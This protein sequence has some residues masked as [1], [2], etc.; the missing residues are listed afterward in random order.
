MNFKPI[1]KATVSEEP[2]IN[3]VKFV[4]ITA[5]FP[6]HKSETAKS[7]CCG[8]IINTSMQALFYEN[9]MAGPNEFLK[10]E[11]APADASSLNKFI[12]S[13]DFDEWEITDSNDEHVCFVHDLIKNSTTKGAKKKNKR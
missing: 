10:F 13:F 11:E 7:L 4:K 1:T 6:V 9:E 3:D 5:V 8:E 12:S 2:S